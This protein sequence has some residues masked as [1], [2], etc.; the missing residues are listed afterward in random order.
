MTTLMAGYFGFSKHLYFVD[1]PTTVWRSFI[2]EPF[3]VSLDNSTSGLLIEVV[4]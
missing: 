3:A 2:Y 1:L 4:N